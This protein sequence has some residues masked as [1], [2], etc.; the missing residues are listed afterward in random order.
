MYGFRKGRLKAIRHVITPSAALTYL[1]GN[2]TRITGPFGY[3][4]AEASYSPYDIGIY[5]QPSPKAS[6]LVSLGLVQSIEGK[7]LSKKPDAKGD[8]QFTKIKFLDYLGI[9]ANYDLLKDSLNWSAVN[10]AAR[11]RLLNFLDLNLASTWD[12]YATDS[13]GRNVD[14]PTRTVDGSL[15]HLRTATAA[16]GFELQSKRYGKSLAEKSDDDQVV[17]EALSL[18]HI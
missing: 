10:I 6:G 2:D 11:T 4:G 16:L 1:P 8:Q 3:N 7:M 5:G 18:I 15:A 12:P 13:L 14:R 17:A 9:N